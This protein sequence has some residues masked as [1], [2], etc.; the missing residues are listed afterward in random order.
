MPDI[1]VV[2]SDKNDGTEE[3]LRKIEYFSFFAHTRAEHYEEYSDS[4][5]LAWDKNNNVIYEKTKD[6]D[7]FWYEYTNLFARD[8]SKK[9]K[10]IVK[11]KLKNGEIREY[12]DAFINGEI[13][14][15][16]EY[17]YIPNMHERR[18][19]DGELMYEKM[20][21]GAETEWC[22]GSK[23][24]RVKIFESCPDG[25]TLIYNTAGKLTD[26]WLPGGIRLIGEYW[27]Y[28]RY[29]GYSGDFRSSRDADNVAL[30][31]REAPREPKPTKGNY[32]YVLR[33]DRP[34][35]MEMWA[36]FSLSGKLEGINVSYEGLSGR[37]ALKAW[38]R[39]KVEQNLNIKEE[40]EIKTQG[41][42]KHVVKRGGFK[43]DLK[44]LKNELREIIKLGRQEREDSKKMVKNLEKGIL[45]SGS[46][47]VDFWQ[48]KTKNRS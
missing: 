16:I 13:V 20:P 2:N 47:S 45:D 6:G 19:E 11:E 32:N 38:F 8:L 35:G 17:E 21:D 14:R 12:G 10:V 3:Y 7:Q 18:W 39:K 5:V 22:F 4:S 1:K 48:N 31:R 29:G 42:R 28:G 26:G 46:V 34:D 9:E 15:D 27:C 33:I 41:G 25:T 37:Q 43:E 36:R 30:R 23:G 44:A 40:F 24:K